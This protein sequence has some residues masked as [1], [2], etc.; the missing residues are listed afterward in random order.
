LTDIWNYTYL[1]WSEDQAEKY[2]HLLID[3]Y[4]KIADNPGLGNDYSIITNNLLGF[5]AGR[6]IIFYRCIE[7]DEIEVIRILHEQM[8]IGSR[9]LDK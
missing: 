1:K 4:I 9:L 7:G 3:T 2:Y 8:N 6:H 5:K